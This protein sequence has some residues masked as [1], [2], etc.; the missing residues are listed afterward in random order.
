L[1]RMGED[2]LEDEALFRDVWED[3]GER[4]TVLS[5]LQADCDVL[6]GRPED[7]FPY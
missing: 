7:Y 4:E 3:E 6:I 5:I 1:E 2:E